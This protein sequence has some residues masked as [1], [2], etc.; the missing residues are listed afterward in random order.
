VRLDPRHP[1]NA[2]VLDYFRPA[3]HD[4]Q[5]LTRP[6]FARA[7]EPFPTPVRTLDVFHLASAEFLRERQPA[8]HLAPYDTRQAAA[9]TAMGI[10]LYDFDAGE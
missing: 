3:L 6:I 5:R 10:V 1:A 8:I 4:P 7:L 9:A 2:S